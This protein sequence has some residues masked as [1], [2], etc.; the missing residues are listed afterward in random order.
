MVK[1]RVL[2]V[3]YKITRGRCPRRFKPC[4]SRIFFFILVS[5]LYFFGVWWDICD[6]SKPRRGCA[7]SADST[8]SQLPLKRRYHSTVSRSPS[9]QSTLS[10]QPSSVSC[11]QSSG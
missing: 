2:N 5:R 3:G 4:R 6:A 7:T 11:E 10:R 9:S 1:V 8:S